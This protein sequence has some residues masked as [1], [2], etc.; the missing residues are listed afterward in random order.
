MDIEVAVVSALMI[1]IC[2]LPFIL[3]VRAKNKRK[4]LL[5]NELNIE[6]N[7]V[8]CVITEYEIW[9][10]SVIGLDTNRNILFANDAGKNVQH[11]DLKEYRSVN[12]LKTSYRVHEHGESRSVIERIEI[13]LDTDAGR[14]KSS[15]KILIFDAE[16][17]PLIE[18]EI[19]I[20]EK[21]E[22]KL[23]EIVERN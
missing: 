10:E 13:V 4:K 11:F 3:I 20:A 23:R 9:R 1:G 18:Q 17:T 7:K 16:E 22:K 21:W 6:A 15:G 12:Q 2:A 8:N 14:G 5:V 19:E